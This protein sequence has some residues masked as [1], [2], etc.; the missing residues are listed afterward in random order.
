MDTN[1][2]D[3]LAVQDMP[4]DEAQHFLIF[5]DGDARFKS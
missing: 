3:T 1:V 4:L 5:G 2:T